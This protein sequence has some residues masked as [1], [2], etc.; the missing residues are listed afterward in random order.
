ME[1]QYCAKVLGT[2]DVQFLLH[3]AKPSGRRLIICSRTT[4]HKHPA[5]VIKET[6]FS[7]KKNK[8]SCSRWSLISTSCSQSGINMKRQK[9][10]CGNFSKMQKQPTC[11]VPETLRRTAA[12]LKAK[13]LTT[14]IDF[15][16]FTQPCIKLIDK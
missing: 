15:I 9:K 8:E 1:V 12:V 11:Q 5:G 10:N 13:L 14:N 3:N 4:S 16:L 7:Y 2:L 6:I